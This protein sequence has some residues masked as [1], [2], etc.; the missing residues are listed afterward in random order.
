MVRGWKAHLRTSR[1]ARRRCARRPTRWGIEPHRPPTL[2]EGRDTSLGPNRE[3]SGAEGGVAPSTRGR[4]WS[5]KSR[6]TSP[7]ALRAI[8][9]D[10]WRSRFH[11]PRIRARTR[12]CCSADICPV[13]RLARAATG[14]KQG[15]AYDIAEE[16]APRA[17]GLNPCQRVCESATKNVAC[18]S[19]QAGT[20]RS[21]GCPALEK[22]GSR[23]GISLH[24]HR[25]RSTCTVSHPNL[26]PSLRPL[27]ASCP[28]S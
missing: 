2:S 10:P 14:H 20:L 5:R 27:L 18:Q 28:R 23:A 11:S 13:K 21:T 16:S 4:S 26:G 9:S 25:G 8:T 1:G 19:P 12:R 22:T 3:G 7:Q 17:C 6:P 24:G 15:R